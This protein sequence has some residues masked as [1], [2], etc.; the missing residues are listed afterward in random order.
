MLATL[1]RIKHK[2]LPTASL[3]EI[4]LDQPRFYPRKAYVELE[5]DFAAWRKDVAY[6]RPP[7]SFFLSFFRLYS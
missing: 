4:S 1:A 6:L 2:V 3:I 7:G 5:D